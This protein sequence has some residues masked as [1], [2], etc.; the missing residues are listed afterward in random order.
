MGRS[1][2]WTKAS[3]ENRAAA[4]RAR[5]AR[6]MR[7]SPSAAQSIIS[8]ASLRNFHAPV[9]ILLVY[10]VYRAVLCLSFSH[11]VRGG[12]DAP[13]LAAAQRSQGLRGCCPACEL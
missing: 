12:A 1:S 7:F 9:Q 11:E 13:P 10:R 8:Q 5:L 3:W 4:L 6:I 2:A